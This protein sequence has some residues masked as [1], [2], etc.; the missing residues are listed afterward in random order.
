MEKCRFFR[1]NRHCILQQ[2]NTFP[3]CA[4]LQY[5]VAENSVKW[6]EKNST[7]YKILIWQKNYVGENCSLFHTVPLKRRLFSPLKLACQLM[8]FQ[9]LSNIS[10][11]GQPVKYFPWIGHFLININVSYFALS[12]V[13][14]RYFIITHQLH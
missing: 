1:K 2:Y 9:F 14:V 12:C 3:Y 13:N 6:K 4:Q 11:V 8:F 5:F 10:D 7:V